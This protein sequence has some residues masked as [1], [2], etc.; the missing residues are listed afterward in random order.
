MNKDIYLY[1]PIYIYIFIYLYIYI[2]IYMYMYVY[3]YVLKRVVMFMYLFI[4]VFA[5]ACIFWARG[6]SGFR[7]WVP[8]NGVGASESRSL[9]G[10]VGRRLFTSV[11]AAPDYL[12][13]RV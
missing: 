13:R 12:G 10:L 1:I 4:Y 5:C 2:L 7:A 8:K 9:C 11:G 3:I 6:S